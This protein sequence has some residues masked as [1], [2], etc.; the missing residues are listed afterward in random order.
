MKKILFLLIFIFNI[1]NSYAS[2]KIAYININHI[3]D[4]IHVNDIISAVDIMMNNTFRGV[5]DVGTGISNK[6]V[7]IVD[8]FKI[9]TIYI[10][11]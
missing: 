9:F 7:D 2:N 3:R 11:P 8:Y 1:G 4:F 10:Y 5:I 6:L